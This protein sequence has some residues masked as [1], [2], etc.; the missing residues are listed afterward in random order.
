MSGKKIVPSPLVD[1]PPPLGGFVKHF[2]D[3]FRPELEKMLREN[4]LAG[5][6]V[7]YAPKPPRKKNAK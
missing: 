4:R 3:Y 2:I 1:H 7:I 6:K 5:V